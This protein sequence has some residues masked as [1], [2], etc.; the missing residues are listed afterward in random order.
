MKPES[1]PFPWE[2][3][4]A[5]KSLQTQH[6]GNALGQSVQGAGEAHG[7]EV[8]LDAGTLGLGCRAFGKDLLH[9]RGA[10]TAVCS[11]G[12]LKGKGTELRACVALPELTRGIRGSV[13]TQEGLGNTECRLEVGDV[14]EEEEKPDPWPNMRLPSISSRGTCKA[15]AA[16]SHAA[17]LLPSTSESNLAERLARAFLRV[18]VRIRR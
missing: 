17:R 1:A 13:G 4:V 9:L 10:H 8:S 7:I 14:C 5:V 2:I 3:T 15:R 16:L 6:G 18:I 12:P 11:D